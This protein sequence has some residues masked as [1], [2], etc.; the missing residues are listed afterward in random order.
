VVMGRAVQ[1][2]VLQTQHDVD[3]WW[4]RQERRDIVRLLEVGCKLA[5]MLFHFDPRSPM[6]VATIG[7]PY[8]DALGNLLVDWGVKRPH[9]RRRF[10]TVR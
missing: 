9:E 2:P 8:S 5:G 4:Y 10:E 6:R 1:R 7:H 3:E